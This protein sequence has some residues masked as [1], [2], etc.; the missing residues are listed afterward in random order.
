[1]N[2]CMYVCINVDDSWG[3]VFGG[4]EMIGLGG[5]GLLVAGGDHI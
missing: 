1:M 4:E 5:G 2:E 3:W